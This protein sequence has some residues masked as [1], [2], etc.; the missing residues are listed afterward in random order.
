M[1]TKCK[2]IF[3]TILRYLMIVPVIYSLI[4]HLF[5]LISSE[6]HLAKRSLTTIF[7]LSF[8]V[9]SIITSTWLCLLAILFL[10][11]ISLPLSWIFALFLIL[12]LNIVIIMIIGLI[13]L[14]AK[15][16]LFF[17]ETCRLLRHMIDSHE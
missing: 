3:S 14:K 7:I 12:I 5:S 4:S 17:P 2:P 10:Y 1:S 16:N 11:L 15:E 8:L 9:G 6:A 13:L